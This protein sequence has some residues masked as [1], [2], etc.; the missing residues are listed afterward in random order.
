MAVSIKTPE[1]IEQMRVAGR[2]AARAHQPARPEQETLTP[3]PRLALQTPIPLTKDP[4]TDNAVFP[5]ALGERDA[6]RLSYHTDFSADPTNPAFRNLIS[7]RGPIEGRPPGEIRAR[8]GSAGRPWR[9]RR[10]RA[11]HP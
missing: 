3:L 11:H 1:Q 2:L 6:K 10:R 5:A 9:R 7:G 4:A 8:P